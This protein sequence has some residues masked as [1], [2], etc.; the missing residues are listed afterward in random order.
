MKN[1]EPT[2]FSDDNEDIPEKETIKNSQTDDTAM[3]SQKLESFKQNQPFNNLNS[4][5][6]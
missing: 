3:N 4:N 1:T 2:G 5:L 6:Q